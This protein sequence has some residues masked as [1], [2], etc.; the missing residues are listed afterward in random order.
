MDLNK[1]GLFKTY[2]KRHTMQ[3]L[4]IINSIIIKIH[5][6]L[7]AKA[8]L[9]IS[10]ENDDKYAPV[11]VFFLRNL[12]FAL[13][14]KFRIFLKNF[15]LITSYKFLIFLITKFRLFYHKDVIPPCLNPFHATD[16][17]LYLLKTP[18][19]LSDFLIFSGEQ[20]ETSVIKW[21]L[22]LFFTTV[23]LFFQQCLKL[24]ILS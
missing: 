18:K 23:L 10:Q 14:L 2:G 7:L 24:Y 16:L 21:V 9:G 11:H 6:F 13:S 8:R 19:N 17:F 5:T 4:N 3:T 12:D 15:N 22:L 1:C 20:K